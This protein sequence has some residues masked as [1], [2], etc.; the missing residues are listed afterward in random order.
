M[1]ASPPRGMTRS[2]VSSCWTSSRTLSRSPGGSTSTASR[3]RPARSRRVA[4]DRRDGRVGPGGLGAAA[5][6]DGVAGLEAEGA[7]LDGDVGARLVDHRDDADGHPD[8][9]H[10][11]AVGPGPV[12]QHRPDGIV[13]TGDGVGRP[14]AICST[15]RASSAAGRAARPRCPPRAPRPRRRR[16]LRGSRRS[17]REHPRRLPGARRPSTPGSKGRSSAR[18]HERGGRGRGCPSSC[19]GCSTGS[20]RL[21]SPRRPSRRAAPTPGGRPRTSR[22]GPEARRARPPRSERR[23]RRAA[24]RIPGRRARCLRPAPPQP[25][26]CRP[27]RSRSRSPGPGAGVPAWRGRG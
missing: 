3:G 23:R 24:A 17:A 2:T 14:A 21:R 15:R 25:T 18:Q 1:S 8:A 26:R 11:Y 4:D 13:L 6:H 5:Q 19:R 16:W 12:G 20:P 10:T 9:P 7:R 22:R 27:A